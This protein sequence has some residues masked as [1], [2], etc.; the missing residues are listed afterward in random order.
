MQKVAHNLTNNHT[1]GIKCVTLLLNSAQDL[2]FAYSKCMCVIFIN[3]YLRYSSPFKA[4]TSCACGSDQIVNVNA[5][6]ADPKRHSLE[7]Y[8]IHNNELQVRGQETRQRSE[9]PTFTWQTASLAEVNDS[10][11]TLK[12]ECYHHERGWP[13][14]APPSPHSTLRHRLGHGRGVRARPSAPPWV[15]LGSRS[16]ESFA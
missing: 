2:L 7:S 13:K 3:I 1:Y 12:K 14:R 15:R 8:H 16:G 5:P 6:T 11:L 4:L 9:T 10:S